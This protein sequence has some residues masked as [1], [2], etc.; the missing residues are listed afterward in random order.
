MPMLI[1]TCQKTIVSDARAPAARR[2][3]RARAPRSR[4]PRS[5][6]RQVE[7]HAATRAPM[8]PHSSANTEKMKSVC[9]S[10]RKFSWFCVP[11]RKPLP[12]SMPGADGD[13]RLDDVVAGA[14][15]IVLRVEEGEDALLLVRLQMPDQSTGASSDD[16]RGEQ[17]EPAQRTPPSTSTVTRPW[18]EQRRRCRGRAAPGSAA[19]GTAISNE[20]HDRRRAGR[21]RAGGVRAK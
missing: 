11:C 16:R 6:E 21:A 5:S 4:C 2:S 15:R 10:G 7:R 18:T 1:T 8:K 19:A 12:Q 20:R 9:C 3:G 17:R 13:L 14:E